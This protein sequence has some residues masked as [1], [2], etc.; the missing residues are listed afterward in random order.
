MLGKKPGGCSY[1]G[2]TR[3]AA[4]LQGNTGATDVALT[5]EEI[6]QIDKAFDTIACVGSIWWNKNQVIK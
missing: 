1:S 2:G 6:E 4:R 3:K 5:V